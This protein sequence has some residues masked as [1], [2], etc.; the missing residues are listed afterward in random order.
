MA[1]GIEPCDWGMTLPRLQQY[2]IG[3]WGLRSLAVRVF[4]SVHVLAVRLHGACHAHAL[5]QPQVFPVPLSDP[6]RVRPRDAATRAVHDT[7]RH[8]L[9]LFSELRPRL[10]TGSRAVERPQREGLSV[11]WCAPGPAGAPGARFPAG[12]PGSR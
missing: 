4:R 11:G 8:F 3:R 2:P 6:G 7:L 10:S 9:T 1:D 12:V 5:R